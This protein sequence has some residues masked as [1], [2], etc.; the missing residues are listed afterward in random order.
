[1]SYKTSVP[2]VVVLCLMLLPA[3][4]VTEDHKGCI[5]TFNELEKSLLSREANLDAL[6]EAFFPV[7]C[8]MSITVEIY[9]YTPRGNLSTVSSLEAL[10]Y[11]YKFRWTLSS[12]HVHVSYC[13][14]KACM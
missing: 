2:L 8:Q 5:S 4:V 12:V 11:D 1:M 6:K 3:I 14:N 9:Y 13:N 10:D 7:N